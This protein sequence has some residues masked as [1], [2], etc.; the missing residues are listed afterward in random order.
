MLDVEVCIDSRVSTLRHEAR[1]VNQNAGCGRRPT[2]KRSVLYIYKNDTLFHDHKVKSIDARL[3]LNE[4]KGS[5]LEV[6]GRARLGRC[7]AAADWDR[8][9]YRDHLGEDV[10]NRLQLVSD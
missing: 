4:V 5:L 9:V 6:A 2:L 3:V 10:E 8:C 1:R 7:L